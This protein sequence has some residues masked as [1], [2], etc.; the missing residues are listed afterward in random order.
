MSGISKNHGKRWTDNDL[1][2]LKKLAKGN[3]PTGLIA[4]KIG[5]SESSVRAKAQEMSVSL[6]PTN[7]SPYNR[8]KR[9]VML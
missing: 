3:T 2:E 8:K 7:Q 9:V 6:K 1:Q 4:N 5:R